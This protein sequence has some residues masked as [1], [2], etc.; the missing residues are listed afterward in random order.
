MILVVDDEEQVRRVLTRILREYGYECRM[1]ASVEEALAR[2]VEDEYEAVLS[3][4]LMPGESGIALL[5][6]L[7]DAAPEV[8]VVMVSGVGDPDFASSALELGAY[9]YVTKP[10][11]ANQVLIAVANAIHRARL[12]RENRSYRVQ[13]EGMV[14]DRTSELTQALTDLQAADRRLREASAET[15]QFL[16]QA[17]EGRDVETGQHIVRMS[18]YSTLLA[19]FCG[20]DEEECEVI[21]LASPMHDVGKIGIADGIL[22][23]P[24]PLSSGEF[25]VI[26]QHVE[27]GYEILAKSDQPLLQVAATIARSHHERW[28][29]EGYSQGLAGLA[30]PREARITAV[31]DVF[32]ALVSRRVY[33]PAFPIDQSVDIIRNGRGSQFDPDVVDAFLAHLDDILDVIAE[34]PDFLMRN[35]ARAAGAEP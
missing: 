10:F 25:E 16:A 2:L 26:K 5:R 4:V 17:I 6:T 3:D 35:P 34:Y 28:D 14:A 29:G 15:I 30:I 8:P 18:R 9:G 21:R 22:F 20:L 11:E 19:R 13:L 23:K 32:D 1:A 7:G 24:G 12:E 27:L 31:A 33:K